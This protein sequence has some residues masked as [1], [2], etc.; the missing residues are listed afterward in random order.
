MTDEE[1]DS[2]A[3]RLKPLLL[4]DIVLIAEVSGRPAAFSMAIPDYNQVLKRL[5]GRLFPTGFLKFLWHARRIDIVRILTLGVKTE[6]RRRGIESMLYLETLRRGNR[7]GYHQCEMSWILE[8][9]DLMRKGCEFL[10]GR[11]YKKYRIYEKPLTGSGG[12][13]NREMA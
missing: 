11:L 12:A 1:I 13:G 4:P 2:M 5:N 8:S 6:Y 9:N 10:G 3:K 7:N